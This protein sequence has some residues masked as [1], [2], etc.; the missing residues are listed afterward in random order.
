MARTYQLISADSH[1]DLSPERWKH[2]VPAAHRDLVSVVRLESGEDAVVV[3]GGRPARIGLTRS[4]GVPRDRLHEQIPTFDNSGGTGSP[5]R[6]I[7]EQDQDGV[8]AE[9]LFSRIQSTLRQIPDDAIFL[10][11]VRAYNDY[12]AEEYAAVAPDRLI[13]MGV[14]PTTGID[15][16]VRELEHCSSLGLKGVL[17]DRFPNGRGAPRPEDDRFWAAALDLRMPVTHHTNGGTTRMTAHD[18][19]TFTYARGV[20][21]DAS[22][23]GHDPMRH[24]FFRF[25][26][27]AACAPVQMAFAGVWDR[28]PA[29]KVYWAETM[30][31]WLE[32]ALWQI[33]D[34]YERYKHL[35]RAVYGLDWLERMPSEYI[36]DHCLWGFLS[37]PV[38]VRR[39]EAVG[40][41]NVMWGSDFA[42]AASDWP[43]S[44]KLIE[45]DFVGVPDD[46]RYQMLA[47][48][49]IE[50]FH[51][52]DQ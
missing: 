2:R 9:I 31:G 24:W 33:D 30:I 21:E 1:L 48:N 14:I 39:R 25:C 11:W 7:E 51:L 27:D 13:P 17:I 42:H 12:L 23:F 3:N 5:E 45:R 4:V 36:R 35:G 16:A 19:Q 28:F 50:F 20:R 40:V 6:R 29:L 26:G 37:D 38:G 8:D 34:H 41:E 32:Y 52:N 18:E 44:R 47:G 10:T 15:D 43:N 22:G 46:E 49:A